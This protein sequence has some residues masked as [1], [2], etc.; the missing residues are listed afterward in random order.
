M[1]RK[2]K[3]KRG[4]KG[5]RREGDRKGREGHGGECTG[6]P[7]DREEWTEGGGGNEEW[8][9]AKGGRLIWRMSTLQAAITTRLKL[10]CKYFYRYGSPTLLMQIPEP[11]FYPW[12]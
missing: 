1:G 6:G 7:I 8:E 12:G 11:V 3:R 10:P 5:K 2:Q 4:R 9:R